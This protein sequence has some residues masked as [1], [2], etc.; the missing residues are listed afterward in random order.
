MLGLLIQ[1]KI[2]I[3][4]GGI[5]IVFRSFWWIWVTES[6]ISFLL[7]LFTKFLAFSCSLCVLLP[8]FDFS[9]ISLDLLTRNEI[10][11]IS[12]NIY[13]FPRESFLRTKYASFWYYLGWIGAWILSI[14]SPLFL[15][16]DTVHPFFAHIL[17]WWLRWWFFLSLL[18]ICSSLISFL[19]SQGLLSISLALKLSVILFLLLDL[20][21][22]IPV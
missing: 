17:L 12:R 19:L 4:L 5:N 16:H 20:L 2:R 11:W 7:L 21:R 8:F 14:S 22:F 10:R 6:F 18:I 9:A 1:R 13:F 3:Y 15:I